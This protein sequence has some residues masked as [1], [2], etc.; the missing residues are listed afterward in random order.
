M[1]KFIMKWI[2]K[3]LQFFIMEILNNGFS[4][5]LIKQKVRVCF[6]TINMKNLSK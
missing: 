2:Y 4:L 3:I 6:K 5:L 1:L